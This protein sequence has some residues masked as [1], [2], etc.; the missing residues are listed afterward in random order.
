[1]TEQLK[2]AGTSPIAFSFGDPEPVLDRGGLTDYME[3]ALVGQWWSPPVSMDGLAT[4]FRA[5]VHHE[6]ALRVKANILTSTFVPHKLLSR[7]SFAALALDYL[8]L[9]NGY[10]HR[11]ANRLGG[12]ARLDVPK[13]RYLRRGR[14]LT[15]YFQVLTTQPY[16][17]VPGQADFEFPDGA[18]CHLFRPDLNQELYGVPEYLSALNSVLLNESATLFR[19]KYY[20]NGAHAGFI[21]YLNDPAQSQEDIDAIREALKNAKGPGNFRNLFFYSPNGKKDGI[22]LI[23]VGEVAAKDEFS[24]IKN[25]SRDDM[26]AIHRV[27]PQLM[28]IVPNNTGGFGDAAQAAA[29]FATNEIEPLQA[30][31]TALND[32]MGEEIITFKLYALAIQT[33][34]P[35]K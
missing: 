31:M 11:V 5:A 9:G 22:Q 28:G 25:I 7:Q 19:R 23:P 20:K 2:S 35:K 30:Q 18:V 24:S 14:V 1:M 16:A 3:C 17:W 26:L 13:A 34:T 33:D 6:S 32:W 10:V 8:V 12:V 29:V 21:L 4:S 15:R 27:P